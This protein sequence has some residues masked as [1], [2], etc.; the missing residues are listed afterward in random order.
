MTVTLPLCMSHP[1]RKKKAQGS[2][3]LSDFKPQWK[4]IIPL[5]QQLWAELGNSPCVEGKGGTGSGGWGPH[6][7]DN[8]LTSQPSASSL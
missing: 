8:H 3:Q 4:V 1:A 2:F 5:P 6:T 7:L